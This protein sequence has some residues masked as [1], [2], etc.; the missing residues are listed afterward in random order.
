M[1]AKWGFRVAVALDRF[2]N[3]LFGGKDD[4]TI[5]SQAAIAKHN[6]RIWG[7]VLCR[8]LN[9]LDKNHCEASLKFDL[10]RAASAINTLE[11]AERS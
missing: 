7:C 10:D 9:L 8:L 6:G 2:L 11:P 4:L 3:V 1:Y 5:S